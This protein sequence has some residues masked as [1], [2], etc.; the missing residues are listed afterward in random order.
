MEIGKINGPRDL[1]PSRTRDKVKEKGSLSPLT[2]SQKPFGGT[3]G[4]EPDVVEVK[5]LKID[6]W[7][8]EREAFVKEV[9]KK[10]ETGELERPEIFKATA[11]KILLR[12]F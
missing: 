10:L 9:K 6:K 5:K 4:V 3:N 7:L 2:K 11:E 1:E 8:K 12:Y